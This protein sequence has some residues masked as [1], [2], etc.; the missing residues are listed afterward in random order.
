MDCSGSQ[1]GTGRYLEV[2]PH[3]NG[4]ARVRLLTGAWAVVD[5]AGA[6]LVELGQFAEEAQHD[7]VSAA[8]KYWQSAALK[9]VLSCN[10]INTVE[11][12][13]TLDPKL[14]EVLLNVACDMGLCTRGSVT[15]TSGAIGVEF[16]V[17]EKG[18]LLGDTATR[19]KCEYWLQDRYFKAWF[20]LLAQFVPAA[21]IEAAS[22]MPDTFRDLSSDKPGLALSQRVLAAYAKQ[23]WH[24]VS[25]LLPLESLL[26]RQAPATVVD[27]AGGTGSLLRE[28]EQ[29]GVVAGKLSLVC[30][31]RPEVVDLARAAVVSES[32]VQFVSGDLFSG[33][34]PSGDLYLLSRV[35][36]DWDDRRAL[37]VLTRVHQQSPA[38]ATLCVIDRHASPDNM[39]SMLS[40]HMYMLQRSFERTAEQWESLFS[41]SSWQ[42]V[43]QKPFAGHVVVMLKKREGSVGGEN[44]STEPEVGTIAGAS[45]TLA[46]RSGP[47]KAVV[48]IA[49]L[50]TR[51]GV[52]SLVTPKALLPVFGRDKSMQPALGLLLDQLLAE[53]T[54]IEQVCI[55]ASPSQLTVLSAYLRAFELTRES[56]ASTPDALHAGSSL[57]SGRLS[58]LRDKISVVVQPTA[59]GFGDAILAA[60]RFVGGEPFT[61]A[62]GDHVFSPGCVQQVVRA[63][64]TLLSKSGNLSED[65]A[66][67]VGLTGACLCNR[68]EIPLTGLLQLA[69]HDINASAAE[70]APVATLVVDMA[71][72]P[73]QFDRFETAPASGKYMSQLVS[74]I[75]PLTAFLHSHSTL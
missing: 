31:E 22:K 42:T 1:V 50:G 8:Q 39:H 75:P 71:E 63:Y 14:K 6:V 72:K 61:V 26:G 4:Q 54:G 57:D 70:Q 12:G 36:H 24:G 66:K 65:A 28:I 38:D 56:G 49:G 18:R 27:L 21:A 35:L 44:A 68:R 25:S 5:E 32:S 74:A 2:E 60:K 53:G 59:L 41:H 13:S 62:L 52:Q 73:Q 3:Y 23:D 9:M 67:R 47:R 19:D 58:Y 37:Q 51:M 34:L 40:L 46:P 33:S 29:S 43:G 16:R 64:R 11:T 10:V 55:V 45:T 15:T 20:P 48:P 69:T 7:L 30:V 17:T